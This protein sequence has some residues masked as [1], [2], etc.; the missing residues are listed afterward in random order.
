MKMKK[1]T[2]SLV[3]SILVAAFLTA[4][5]QGAASSAPASSAAPSQPAAQSQTSSAPA[6]DSSADFPEMTIN[7]G[8][9]V[10]TDHGYHKGLEQ[11][12]R[13]HV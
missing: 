4:C 10:A 6:A 9:S 12:G 13:A 1:R 7:V 5:G 8:H 3:S 11:I 2:L